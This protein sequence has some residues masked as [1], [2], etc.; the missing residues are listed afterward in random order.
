MIVKTFTNTTLNTSFTVTFTDNFINY[1]VS[2][3]MSL[4]QLINYYFLPSVYSTNNIPIGTNRIG[5]FTT[6]SSATANYDNRYFVI[7]INGFSY[8]NAQ[9]MQ[10]CTFTVDNGQAQS[11]YYTYPN[12]TQK[13]ATFVGV[14]LNCFDLY[15]NESNIT[16]DYG[17]PAN[18]ATFQN[19]L[20]N[21]TITNTQSE[22]ESE[23]SYSTLI[24]V[25]NH[26]YFNG[27]PY[28]QYV[29]NNV[30][31]TQNF[32]KINDY[33]Y[34]LQFNDEVDNNSIISIIANNTIC[35]E[36][37]VNVNYNIS[38]EVTLLNRPSE[39]YE[40]A[41]PKAYTMDKNHSYEYNETKIEYYD[42]N[43]VLQ[44]IQG[45][46]NIDECI[47]II[48]NTVTF[49]PNSTL[50]VIATV[51]SNTRDINYHLSNCTSNV[52][53]NTYTLGDTINFIFTPNQYYFFNTLVSLSYYKNGNKLQVDG[54]INNN[55]GYLTLQ[56]SE[57]DLNTDID[58]FA[59]AIKED[60]EII[61]LYNNMIGVYKVSKENI[62]DIANAR[63]R[64]VD[65]E[66]IYQE[67]DL[68]KYINSLKRFFID[69]TTITRGTIKLGNTNINSI[70]DIVENCIY[71]VS[72]GVKNIPRLYNTQND[73][74][75]I[76]VI[77]L[78]PFSDKITLDNS[79]IGRNIRI[80]Y[81]INIVSDDC[82][83]IFYDD[84]T[85]E[86]LSIHNANI[87]IDVPYKTLSENS[88]YTQNISND[89]S[90]LSLLKNIEPCIILRKNKIINTIYNNTDFTETLNNLNGFISISNCNLNNIFALK[91]ELELI[92][93]ELK[94]GIII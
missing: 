54:I 59:T 6:N 78:L 56:L 39:I 25:D 86:I 4:N 11:M 19:N 84:D 44:T 55:I 31:L 20:S 94:N 33:Q 52:S 14:N 91:E 50:N 71:T 12:D 1:L 85:D 27:V 66:Y 16:L 82:K 15:T 9:N 35:K 92:E 87:S 28:I 83:I 88:D 23:T 81:K 48:P 57:I 77:C 26:Y 2:L 80:D 79:F 93:R 37:K 73:F 24:N 63:Y 49:K 22:Y 41:L 36:V 13:M 62:E 89:Y 65:S 53:P 21:C 74:T 17:T 38:N 58:I 45:T 70:S 43:D 5:D 30:T 76:Q 18:K 90:G 61:K 7:G 10:N 60:S 64:V 29:K 69:V 72:L 34:S 42:K 8:I 67:I 68:G 47:I 46:I 32:I 51:Q 3:G 40:N 75:D